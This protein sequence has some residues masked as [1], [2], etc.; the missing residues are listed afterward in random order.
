MTVFLNSLAALFPFLLLIPSEHTGGFF[1]P[2]ERA[3]TNRYRGFFALVVVLHHM[4]QRVEAKGLLWIYFDAGFLAVAMFFFYSGYGLM[5]KGIRQ[6]EGFFRKR[7]PQIVI[8]YVVTMIIYWFLYSLAGDAKTVSSLMGEHLHNESGISF[9]WFV[10]VYLAWILFLGVCLRFMHRD[11]QILYAAVIF[12]L[13]FVAFGVLVTPGLFWIYDTVIMIP[14]GCAWAYDEERI[15]SLIQKQY[16]KVLVI[17]LLLFFVSMPG[18]LHPVLR[19]PAYMISSVTFMVFLNTASMKR[20]PV[21][22]VLSFLGTISFE[23]YLLHG[24]PVTFGK[25]LI[26][27]EGLWTLSVVIIALISAYLMHLLAERSWKPKSRKTV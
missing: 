26:V 11:K 18:H 8:P 22:K 24:I 17:S 19:I 16:R 12:A 7:I 14:M 13:G 5:K 6:K 2:T 9:L 25:A 15:V 23:I 21:G 4:A 27:N 10:F 3:V 20:K 1:S